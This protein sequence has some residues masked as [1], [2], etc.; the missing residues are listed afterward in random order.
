MNFRAGSQQGAWKR[1]IEEEGSIHCQTETIS[2][3]LNYRFVNYQEGKDGREKSKNKFAGK[4]WLHKQ[5]SEHVPM[6]P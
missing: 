3:I 5:A 2:G 4:K 6:G 1:F